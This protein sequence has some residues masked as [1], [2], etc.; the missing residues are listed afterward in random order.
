M[1]TKIYL[2]SIMAISI[3]IKL[4]AQSIKP[5][6]EQNNTEQVTSVSADNKRILVH[7]GG[8]AVPDNMS[9]ENELSLKT[10]NI[11]GENNRNELLKLAEALAYQA[12]RLRADAGKKAGNEKDQMLAEAALFERN[13]LLKQIEASEIYGTMSQV[14]FN[15]NKETINKLISTSKIDASSMSR[16]RQL[17]TSSEKNMQLAKDLRDQSSTLGNAEE[18]EVLALSEQSQ[19]INLLWKKPKTEK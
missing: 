16:S 13:C 1:K 8:K 2:V 15:S 12:K 11:S 3:G 5:S 7:V 10:A 19:A 18:K 17:V 9:A 6:A 14:K 4:N